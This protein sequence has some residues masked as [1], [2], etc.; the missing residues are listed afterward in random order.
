MV[1]GVKGTVTP[2]ASVFPVEEAQ[3]A[4]QRVG[5]TIT[6]RQKE[7]DHLRQFIS[8]NRALINLVQKLP[9][10][11]S[12]EIMVPFGRAAF[13]P[14]RLI[15]TNELMV[16]LGDGYYAE[17]TAKQTNEI[18]Q[19]RGKALEG[20]CDSLKAMIA[21]LQA[22]V[23][24][25]NNTAAEAAEGLVEIREE[26]AEDHPASTIPQSGR[27]PEIKHPE[28][29]YAS[30]VKENE[31]GEDAEYARM[32]ARLDVLEKEEEA[33]FERDEEEDVTRFVSSAHLVKANTLVKETDSGSAGKKSSTT[34]KHLPLQSEQ[35]V[36][37]VH[38][39]TTDEK[40]STVSKQSQVIIGSV[41]EHSH[42]FPSDP[43]RETSS[44]VGTSK[45]SKPVS[46]F[47]MQ[48]GNS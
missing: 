47:K 34:E 43:N 46:R 31:A 42:G 38:P 33:T 22:E 17:R 35:E 30:G 4:V 16:L 40:I 7:L 27:S 15:H 9:D 14:G 21:D 25:F 24:F 39:L 29:S 48:R 19:R 13:F 12:H 8:D 37:T 32:M 45:P 41:V 20:Q 28:S 3:K 5:D 10:E 36:S 1:G 23:S 11:I 44:S 6:Q 2:L 18:L 26:Y